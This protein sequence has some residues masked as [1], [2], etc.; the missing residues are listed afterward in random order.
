MIC[1]HQILFHCIREKKS[2]FVPVSVSLKQ[3]NKTS[4][5]GSLPK[6]QNTHD[7]TMTQAFSKL[8]MQQQPTASNN[9]DDINNITCNNNAK[10]RSKTT[11]HRP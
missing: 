8:R 1:G 10:A 2:L 11:K 9:D 6:E 4:L 5:V 7:N 3:V